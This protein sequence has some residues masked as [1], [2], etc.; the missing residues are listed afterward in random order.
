[1]GMRQNKAI[2][3]EIITHHPTSLYMIPLILLRRPEHR[4]PLP[5]AI[6][7]ID[8]LEVFIDSEHARHISR[9]IAVVRGGP[10]RAERTAEHVFVP[11]LD[12]LV[13]TSDEGEGVCVVELERGVS[14]VEYH[15][16]S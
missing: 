10:D 7:L 11:L 8:I 6:F 3:N 13:G 15:E 5:I 12:Q 16:G 4:P 2:E 1:M 9:A 14:I